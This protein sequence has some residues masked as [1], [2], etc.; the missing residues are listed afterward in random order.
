MG[1]IEQRFCGLSIGFANRGAAI[2]FLLRDLNE[3]APV[4]SLLGAGDED[5]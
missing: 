2:V 1:K 4:S 3:G 5:K